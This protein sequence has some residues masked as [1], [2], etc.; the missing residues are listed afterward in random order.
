MK[1][2]NWRDWIK[3]Y[4]LPLL[5]LAISV[6]LTLLIGIYVFGADDPD[7]VWVLGV[8]PVLAFLIGTIARPAH[9]WVV[10]LGVAILWLVGAAFGR[11]VDVVPE[12]VLPVLLIIGLPLTVLIWLGKTFGGWLDTRHAA[13]PPHNSPGA[14]TM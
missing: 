13:S 10:P 1:M 7:F 8:G 4:A 14:P 11:G 9:V 3:P 5:I 6:P 2:M 12:M